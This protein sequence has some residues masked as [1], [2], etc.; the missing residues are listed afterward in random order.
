MNKDDLDK[1]LNALICDTHTLFGDVEEM[2]KE[3][4]VALLS[5]SGPA[6]TVVREQVYAQI[7]SLVKAMRMQPFGSKILYLAPG[8]NN[9]ADG[10]WLPEKLQPIARPAHVPAGVAI[11]SARMRV[12]PGPK[13]WTKIKSFGP[14]WQEGVDDSHFL[15]YRAEVS[16]PSETNLLVEYPDG[17]AVVPSAN[18]KTLA[19]LGGTDTKSV[20]QLGQGREHLVVLYE[21]HGHANGGQAME[22]PS[23]LRAMSTSASPLAAGTAIGGWRMKIVEGTSNRPEVDPAFDDSDWTPVPVDNLEANQLTPNQAAVFRCKSN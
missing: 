13:H 2:D 21:N 3:E 19:R 15:F 9:P 23:G 12:D 14:L 20:F 10:E 4:A 17:D 8:V 22:N 16:C 7:D 18:G 6:A 11:T 1:D 5:D